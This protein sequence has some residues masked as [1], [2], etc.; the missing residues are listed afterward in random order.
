MQLKSIL[1]IITILLVFSCSTDKNQVTKLN[2]E[3]YFNC[4][5]KQFKETPSLKELEKFEKFL[6]EKGLLTKNHTSYKKFYNLIMN[7]FDSVQQIVNNFKFN[8]SYNSINIDTNRCKLRRTTQDIQLK[9]SLE[10]YNIK[11]ESQKIIKLGLKGVNNLPEKLFKNRGLQLFLINKQYVFF[12]G[13]WEKPAD[14]EVTVKE[15]YILI[16]NK[17][18]N[19]ENLEMEVK[20]IINSKKL[21][22]VKISL[23]WDKKTKLGRFDKVH[24]ILKNIENVKIKLHTTHV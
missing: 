14:I 20:N 9:D 2:K 6:L 12:Q 16:G 17:S 21:N 1:H 15:N 19:I 23:Y 22:E 13:L 4:V 5:E 3:G 18:T 24:S 8:S 7:Q 10:F 11:N